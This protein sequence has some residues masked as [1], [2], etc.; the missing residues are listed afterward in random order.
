MD[1]SVPLRLLNALYRDLGPTFIITMTPIASALID[2]TGQNLS[3]FSYF[4][5][6]AL[7]TIPGSD[8]KLISWFDVMFYGHFG[9]GPPVYES[10]IE[11]GWAPERIVMTVLASSN[12]GPP[13]CF[14]RIQNLESMIREL[15]ALYPRFGGLA[16]WEYFDAGTTDSSIINCWDWVKRVGNALF[17]TIPQKVSNEEL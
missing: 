11:A 9:K 6:D 7:A 17:N 15:R 5:L 13:N 4:D 14:T 8:K 1:I 16:V 2:E 10:V 3:G 12:V